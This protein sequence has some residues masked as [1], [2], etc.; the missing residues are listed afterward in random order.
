[1]FCWFVFYACLKVYIIYIMGHSV[2]P[3]KK[4][5]DLKVK[6]KIWKGSTFDESVVDLSGVMA[7]L[8]TM[9]K[10]SLPVKFMVEPYTDEDDENGKV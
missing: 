10:F 4:E 9:K 1:M 3:Q 8:R 7:I 5:V 2:K 6:L